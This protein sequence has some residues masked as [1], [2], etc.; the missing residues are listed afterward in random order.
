MKKAISII[1]LL[2]VASVGIYAQ[3]KG[4]DR[5]TG[6]IRDTG[7]SRAPASNG[8]KQDVGAGRGIDFGGGKTPTPPPTPNPYRLTGRRDTIIK[9]IEDLMR[10]RKLVLDTAASK[11]DDGI[12]ISQPFIFSKGAVVTESELNRYADLPN[13]SSR[14]WT[15]GRYTYIVEV[16][17]IDGMNTNVSV[18]VKLE[19]RTDGVS[20]AE[21]VTLRSNGTAE[22][23]FLNA[24]IENVTG[25]PAPGR[26]P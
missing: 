1:F 19:G 26:T 13:A 21:W 20:G 4:V 14:G 3:E 16:Q 6:N 10:D 25:A 24:L 8:S 22:Q 15:R 5:Q 7:N 17:P 9:A 11:P 12:L 23:E 2:V 18:N